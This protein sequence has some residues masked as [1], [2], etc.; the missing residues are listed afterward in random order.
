MRNFKLNFS[1]ILTIFGTKALGLDISD[2]S[3]ELVEV[4][5]RGQALTVTAF[6]RA[7]LDKGIVARG[8]IQDPYKL[9]AIIRKLA[10]E[11]KP[12]PIILERGVQVALPESQTYL[13]TFSL[14]RAALGGQ[15]NLTTAIRA[16]VEKTF[17]FPLEE[18][19]WNSVIQSE[20][21][22]MYQ[23]AAAAATREVVAEWREAMKEAG[24][25]VKF[26]DLESLAT[27]RALFPRGVMSLTAMVDL[28]AVTTT[29]SLFNQL[30]VFYAYSL[31][32]GGEALTAEIAKT[33]DLGL[34]AAEERK[35]LNGLSDRDQNLALLLTK[36]LRPTLDELGKLERYLRSQFHQELAEVVLVGG[37]SL[38]PGLVD[39]F[40]RNLKVPVRRGELT[41]SLT[42]SPAISTSLTASN[43]LYLEAAGLALTPFSLS[44]PA[45]ALPAHF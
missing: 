18:L 38:L 36:A 10:A 43:G 19:V 23:V 32:E 34:A 39:Y 8:R 45:L 13:H 6:G 31:N 17:P 44:T 42:L 14:P 4:R 9:A 26:F 41:S 2:R 35:V 12:A 24:I 40:A 5:K 29:I 28:G 21:P 30:G 3:A 7:S 22:E 16:E 25:A 11:A 33:L 1:K 27:F 20:S 15:E 37:G